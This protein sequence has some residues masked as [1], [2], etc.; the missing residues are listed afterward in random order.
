MNYSESLLNSLGYRL[1]QLNK[2]AKAVE[3]LRLSMESFPESFNTYDSFGEALMA[4][5]ETELAIK[6]YEKS[7]E[8]D[9]DNGNAKEMLKKLKNKQ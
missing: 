3:I 7:V 4:V 6:N 2:P 1:I 8:L 5:G 9:P